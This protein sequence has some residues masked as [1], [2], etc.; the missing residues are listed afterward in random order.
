MFLQSKSGQDEKRSAMFQQ[1]LSLSCV[2]RIVLVDLETLARLGQ[3]VSM[4]VSLYIRK[5]MLL[6]RGIFKIFEST[7]F[8]SLCPCSHDPICPQCMA[9]HLSITHWVSVALPATRQFLSEASSNTI[10]TAA[11]PPTS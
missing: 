6:S 8:M 3:I 2:H 11:A 1:S 9:L 4:V 7:F 5:I 10:R